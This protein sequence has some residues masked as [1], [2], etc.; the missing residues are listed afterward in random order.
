MICCFPKKARE[1]LQPFL[2]SVLILWHSNEPRLVQLD[3]WDP[4][5]RGSLWL[6]NEGCSRKNDKPLQKQQPYWQFRTRAPPPMTKLGGQ[7]LSRA[8]LKEMVQRALFIWNHRIGFRT[9]LQGKVVGWEGKPMQRY[10]SLLPPR[11]VGNQIWTDCCAWA[12]RSSC[13]HLF[14]T[15]PQ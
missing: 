10:R 7:S 3:P 4:L 2:R 5:A 11:G 13:C 15:S 9:S 1:C 14:Q 12:R 8:H 6:K